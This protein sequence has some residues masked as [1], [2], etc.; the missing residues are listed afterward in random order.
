M[1]MESYRL[2][3]GRIS[4]AVDIPPIETTHLNDDNGYPTISLGLTDSEIVSILQNWELTDYR[5]PHEPAVGQIDMEQAIEL[6]RAGLDFL[7]NHNI[8]PMEMLEFN[9]VGAILSQNVPQGGQFLPLRYSYWSVRFSNEH[10]DIF[11]TINA[12]TGQI[13]RTEIVANS[14]Y[15]VEQSFELSI[16]HDEVLN[17]LAAFMSCLGIYTNQSPITIWGNRELLLDHA[18]L[19]Q[20]DAWNKIIAYQSFANGD[21]AIIVDASGAFV[22]EPDGELHFHRLDIYLRITRF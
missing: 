7:Y 10:I 5:R 17:M 22:F 3:S 21:A 13:W 12:V 4:F 9:N 2:L 6:G 11:M 8:L 18:N 16:S 19:V 14:W 15:V 20:I 1:D